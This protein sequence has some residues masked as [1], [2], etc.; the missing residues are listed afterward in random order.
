MT[1]YHIITDI[2]KDSSSD[3]NFDQFK[4][5]FQKLKKQAAT[6]K[7]IDDDGTVYE[8]GGN[9]VKIILLG[10]RD[11]SKIHRKI[12]NSG[13][14]A[15]NFP[16][17][18]G[19][20]G[21]ENLVDVLMDSKGVFSGENLAFVIEEQYSKNLVTAIEKSGNTANIISSNYKRD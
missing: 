11:D 17:A 5:S 20:S 12:K 15:I 1:T 18:Y 8:T 19:F 21:Y 13:S 2:P 3:F 16:E 4:K 7:K 10:V 6:I 9:E 14:C